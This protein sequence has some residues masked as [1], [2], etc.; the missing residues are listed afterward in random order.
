MEAGLAGGH[1][2]TD[3]AERAAQLALRREQTREPLPI[4]RTA[5]NIE[6][7]LAQRG[8]RRPGTDERAARLALE[9]QKARELSPFEPYHAMPDVEHARAVAHVYDDNTIPLAQPDARRLPEDYRTATRAGTPELAA[10]PVRPIPTGEI[11]IESEK[12]Y[13][14]FSAAVEDTARDRGVPRKTRFRGELGGLEDKPDRT[15]AE[16]IRLGT[17]VMQADELEDMGL[18]GPRRRVSDEDILSL[19]MGTTR[20]RTPR[21]Q[22]TGQV[23]PSPPRRPPPTVVPSKDEYE[24]AD[25]RETAAVAPH[26]ARPVG[27]EEEVPVDETSRRRATVA[28]ERIGLFGHVT[29]THVPAKSAARLRAEEAVRR[30]RSRPVTPRSIGDFLRGRQT[31]AGG[32]LGN[33]PNQQRASILEQAQAT[34][35]PGLVEDVRTGRADVTLSRSGNVVGA[36]RRAER[37]KGGMG[38]GLGLGSTR[39]AVGSRLA[40]VGQGVGR[41]VSGLGFA[42]GASFAPALLEQTFGTVDKPTGDVRSAARAQAVG[43]GLQTA[44]VGAQIGL[45]AGPIGAALGAAVGATYGFVNA[46]SEANNRIKELEF[47]KSFNAF[48]AALDDIAND[49]RKY[50]PRARGQVAAGLASVNEEARR[51]VEAQGGGGSFFDRNLRGT[52]LGNALDFEATGGKS[53]STPDEELYRRSAKLQSEKRIELL[54][55]KLPE[56]HQIGE[57]IAGSVQLSRAELIAPPDASQADLEARRRGRL[58]RF[59]EGGGAQIAQTISEVQK[60]P[61]AQVR[62]SFDRII[63]SS[64]MLRLQQEAETQAVAQATIQLHQFTQVEQAVNAASTSLHGLQTQADHLSQAFGGSIVASRVGNFSEAAGQVG[65]LDREAFGRS[66]D[67][68]SANVGGATGPDF[69]NVMRQVDATMRDLPAAISSADLNFADPEALKNSLAGLLGAGQGNLGLPA[70]MQSRISTAVEAMDP[71]RLFKGVTADPRKLV[72][73]LIKDSFGELTQVLQN[74]AKGLEAEFNKFGTGLAEYGQMLQ[75]QGESLDRASTGRLNAQRASATL[76]AARTGRDPSDFLSLEDLRRPVVERQQRLAG[77]DAFNPAGIAGRVTDAY[78]RRAGV[79]QQLFQAT[80][81]GD[82]PENRLRIK[83][84]Q[85]EFSAITNEATSLQQALEHL[86][87]ASDETAAIQEKLNDIEKQRQGQFSF[88]EKLLTANPQQRREMQRGAQLSD[89]AV[90]QGSLA[91]FNPENIGRIMEHL[92]SLQDVRLPDYGGRT[93]GQVAEGFIAGANRAVFGRG[94]T[95]LERGRDTL[96]QQQE[97]VQNTAVQAQE[98]I[99]GLQSQMA[100]DFITN[101]NAQNKQFL[102]KMD[103]LIKSARLSDAQGAQQRAAVGVKRSEVAVEGVKTVEEIGNLQAPKGAARV[104][105]GKLKEIVANPEFATLRAATAQSRSLQAGEEATRNALFGEFDRKGTVFG[106]NLG[107]IQSGENQAAA[108]K[109]VTEQFPNVRQTVAAQTGLPLG[110]VEQVVF[111]NLL[112]QIGDYFKQDKK[113][114]PD[115]FNVGRGLIGATQAGFTE[116]QTAANAQVTAARRTIGVAAFG[117]E[118]GTMGPAQQVITNLVD[119]FDKV[120]QVLAALPQGL[121][122]LGDAIKIFQEKTAARKAADQAVEQ[123]GGNARGGI[124]FRSRGTDTVPAMLTP[125]EFV[126]NAAATRANLSILQEINAAR[127]PAY[128]ADGGEVNLS[129]LSDAIRGNK[130]IPDEIKRRMAEAEMARRGRIA[131]PGLHESVQADRALVEG[132]RQIALARGR[133]YAD[134][135]A[136]KQRAILAEVGG[137]YADEGNDVGANRVADQLAYGPSVPQRAAGIGGRNRAYFDYFDKAIDSY[138][139]KKTRMGDLGA[140]ARNRQQLQSKIGLLQKTGG[141]ADSVQR[142]QQLLTK[143]DSSDIGRRLIS[144]N[145]DLA[146]FNRP[147][148]GDPRGQRRLGVVNAKGRSGVRS[149]R[150]IASQRSRYQRSAAREVAGYR[151]RHA[152]FEGGGLVPAMVSPGEFVINA[153]SAQANRHVLNHINASRGPIYRAAGGPIGGGT[154]AAG[155]GAT[156]VSLGSYVKSTLDGFVG[157]FSNVVGSLSDPIDKLKSAADTFG[158]IGRSLDGFAT[159]ASSLADRLGGFNDAASSLAKSLASVNIPPKIEMAINGN[160][161]VVLNGGNMFATMTRAVAEQVKNE[162][163]QQLG[164]QIQKAIADAPPR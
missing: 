150:A 15:K 159:S 162:I 80:Q 123:A 114:R 67:F 98:K 57:K 79:Q 58:A 121:A 56:F 134:E 59:D 14:T 13:H 107:T 4:E 132:R 120:N 164:G 5:A 9:R 2:Y 30:R 21:A 112:K 52:F 116:A 65:G 7:G 26:Y 101:L 35:D 124:M 117:N 126:V 28:R 139:G 130:R 60:I 3:A 142:G 88:T 41:Q 33:L 90:R 87:D 103:A 147:M 16:N 133:T 92:R 158:N 6:A 96:L 104:D 64:N 53:F 93:G 137:S 22:Y 94:A 157:N 102:D 31:I 50:D 43:A 156:V 48:S 49:R 95:T 108:I 84:L 78:R 155:G 34:L 17:H 97:G 29:R 36:Q 127:G 68:V 82:T 75:R 25:T 61:L 128:F 11:Q 77:G 39:R 149:N 24:L 138:K 122:S 66:L 10:V 83:G 143:L 44:A 163:L 69:S 38:T 81:G 160:Y 40:G 46:L 140:A 91:G 125:G 37:Q 115:T 55:P 72:E 119:N 62:E 89:V 118:V 73:D 23:A 153:E 145:A 106:E 20:G 99:A 8:T 51:S 85:D 42:V 76:R 129:V 105:V 54:N 113:D 154:G 161:N 18:I 70:E 141:S 110:Q 135:R 32:E 27:S 12:D 148:I 152:Y 71:E 151:R 144:T 1:G 146:E 63:Q 111:P 45:A 109:R 47:E 86:A 100:T 131:H 74:V 19:A 136:T